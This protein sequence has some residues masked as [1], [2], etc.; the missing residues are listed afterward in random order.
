MT[1]MILIVDLPRKKAGYT[2]EV[3]HVRIRN[4]MVIQ[5]VSKERFP[6]R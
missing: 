3:V 5:S 1:V 4:D 2:D 6:S